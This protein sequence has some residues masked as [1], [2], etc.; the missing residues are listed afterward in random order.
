MDRGTWRAHGVAKELHGGLSL[1]CIEFVLG[2]RF[3]LLLMP[4]LLC[5]QGPLIPEPSLI[6]WPLLLWLQGFILSALLISLL[7]IF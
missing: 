2:P 7:F 1:P 6:S 4:G 5:H 3:Q